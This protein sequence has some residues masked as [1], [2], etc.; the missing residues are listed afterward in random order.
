MSFG[1]RVETKQV[2]TS[3]LYTVCP[4]ACHGACG[5]AFETVR[6]CASSTGLPT[7]VTPPSATTSKNVNECVTIMDTV[8]CE[9]QST[10]SALH[11]VTPDC[12]LESKS[13]FR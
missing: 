1:S 5:T 4:T 12:V 2:P 11:C 9:S 10:A 7:T 6:N 8:D 13:I 3:T